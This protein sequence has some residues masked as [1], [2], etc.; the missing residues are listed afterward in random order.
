M[1]DVLV[2]GTGPAGV[3]LAAGLGQAG[4]AVGGLSPT[5]VT[6]PWVNT[7]SIWVD[8]VESLGLTPYLKHR[9]KDC[10]VYLNDQPLPLNREYGLLDNQRLQARWLD[11]AARHQVQWHQ[12]K[13]THIEHQGTTCTVTTDTG[14]T[15]AARL[16]VDA[17]GHHSPFMQRPAADNVAYQAAYGIVGRF[18]QPP[19]APQ[20][21]VLMDYRD[22]HLSPTERQEPPTFL[23]AMDLGDGVYFVEETSLAHTPAIAL[24]VLEKRLYQRLAHHQVE[25]TEIHHIER[26]LFPMN[27]PLPDL[28]QPILGFGGAASMVHPATGYMMGSILRR[29]PQVVEAIAQQIRHPDQRSADLAE[30]GWQ[31]LWPD[32]RVRKYYLYRFGLENLLVWKGPRLRQ[33]F[34]TFFSL[35]CPEWS[36]FLADSLSLPDLIVAMLV[37]FS[38]AP[39]GVRWGLMRSV[40]SHSALLAQTFL[41]RSFRA[42]TV[43][44]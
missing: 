10:V 40:F 9:W 35:S 33:F 4:L 1:L 34:Q 11:Q 14:E 43:D 6:D 5:A 31:A 15:L 3:Y 29:G 12:G 8:E 41:V 27:M 36:G 21:M 32:E 17:S 19:I 13:A 7:Y 44:S 24:N 38:K 30:A 20:R 16:V 26:C 2:I 25:V 23:Y 42:K 37:L 22:D 28:Q 18:S 39:N